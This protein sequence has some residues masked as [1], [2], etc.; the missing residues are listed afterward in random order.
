MRFARGGG[1]L[2][3][4]VWLSVALWVG[5]GLV[6]GAK[7]VRVSVLWWECVL[8]VFVRLDIAFEGPR[9]SIALALVD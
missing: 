1:L 5:V 2:A 9:R 7:G 6:L 4:G 8:V 3:V